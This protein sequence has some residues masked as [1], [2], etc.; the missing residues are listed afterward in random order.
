MNKTET[1]LKQIKNEYETLVNKLMELSE[2]ELME[3]YGGSF[4]GSRDDII[5]MSVLSLKGIQIDIKDKTYIDG[6][7]KLYDAIGVAILDLD[8]G[9]DVDKGL[10][11][12]TQAL[13]SLSFLYPDHTEDA[14]LLYHRLYSIYGYLQ[15][16]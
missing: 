2:D 15:K 10:K 6:Y 5:A 1:E 16:A 8:P 12:I 11:D 4:E 3:V 9:K 13:K 7:R 14:D